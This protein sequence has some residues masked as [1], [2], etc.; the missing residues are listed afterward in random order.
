ME[1]NAAR[2]CVQPNG[3]Y[4]AM[5][6]VATL[7]FNTSTT[8]LDFFDSVSDPGSDLTI[9]AAGALAGTAYGLSNRVLD[10]TAFYGQKNISSPASDRLRFRL[11]IDPNAIT[12]PRYAS[13]HYMYFRDERLAAIQLYYDSGYYIYTNAVDD[14]WNYTSLGAQAITD[15]PHYVEIDIVAHASAGSVTQWID[16]VAAGSV[17]GLNNDAMMDAITYF[18]L[19]ACASIDSGTSGTFYLDEFIMNDDGG[20]IGPV[21]AAHNPRHPVIV[22]NDPGVV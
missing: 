7:G 4:R 20:V 19:G 11:Y 22:M 5:S 12:I 21:V 9:D 8:L 10:T 1:P 17:T 3:Y 14:A 6:V 2:C 15:A 18:R 13:F 16:G